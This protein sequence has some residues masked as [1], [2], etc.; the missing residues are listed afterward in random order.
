L[1]LKRASQSVDPFSILRVQILNLNCL[2]ATGDCQIVEAVDDW[3]AKGCAACNDSLVL[4]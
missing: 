4:Q 1:K 3:N 2:S